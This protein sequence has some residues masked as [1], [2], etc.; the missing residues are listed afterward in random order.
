MYAEE[1]VV[2]DQK[3]GGKEWSLFDMLVGLVGWLADRKWVLVLR[4]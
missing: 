4:E 3:G 1:A 2:L